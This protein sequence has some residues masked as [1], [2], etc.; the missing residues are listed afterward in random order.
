MKIHTRHRKAGSGTPKSRFRH[1]I[2]RS[3]VESLPLRIVEIDP[4]IKSE[5]IFEKVAAAQAMARQQEL[6]AAGYSNPL[7][8]SHFQPAVTGAADA[9]PATG[10]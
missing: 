6:E 7:P 4:R 9:E 8:E 1:S 2:N 5:F 3:T 10:D